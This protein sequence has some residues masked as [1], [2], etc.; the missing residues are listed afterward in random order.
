MPENG[1]HGR[2]HK[3]T[4]SPILMAQAHRHCLRLRLDG[5]KK[6]LLPIL[7]LSLS[8]KQEKSTRQGQACLITDIPQQRLSSSLDASREAMDGVAMVQ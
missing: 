7:S 2:R 3:S 5:D 6:R 1:C 8:L 4:N